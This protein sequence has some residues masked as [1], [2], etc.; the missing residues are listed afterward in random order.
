MANL[1]P[2]LGLNP[3]VPAPAVHSDVPGIRILLADAASVFR[4]GLRA[5]L[6]AQPDLEVVAEAS[7]YESVLSMAERFRPGIILFEPEG[8]GSALS[9]LRDLQGSHLPSR[10]ILLTATEDADLLSQS[11]RY[12][13]A[14]IVSKKSPTELLLQSIRTVNAGELWLDLAATL[15]RTD[16]PVALSRREH[17]ITA[18]VAQ[19]FRNLEIADK[20]FISEQTVKNHMHN[21]F[22]KAGV[23][24]RLELAL[25]AI[26]HRMNG[27][28]LASAKSTPAP[29]SKVVN[30]VDAAPAV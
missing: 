30:P 14:G 7:D 22:E 9:I 17:E 10:V 11:L 18:L 5:L 29:R 6:S 4:D 3:E 20:L 2:G 21:I 28:G 8:A 16:K 1:D 23:Q 24:D 25:Y 19:G 15:P 12:G 27:H 13:V 26:Y